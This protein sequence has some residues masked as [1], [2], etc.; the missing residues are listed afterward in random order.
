MQLFLILLH[1]EIESPRAIV[2]DWKTI[3]NDNGFADL[4]Y[5]SRRVLSRETR[6]RNPFTIVDC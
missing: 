3:R 4:D 2:Y 1:I 6:A 5:R